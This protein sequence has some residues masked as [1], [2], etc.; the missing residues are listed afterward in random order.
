MQEAGGRG[1]ALT[2]GV[3]SLLLA[4]L[5]Q[6]A[7]PQA[8]GPRRRDLLLA[9]PSP[10]QPSDFEIRVWASNSATNRF[11]ARQVLAVAPGTVTHI[12]RRA[13]AAGDYFASADLPP[14]GQAGSVIYGFVSAFTRTARNNQLPL[15][16]H[17]GVSAPELI[18]D[19][20]FDPPGGDPRRSNSLV[21]VGRDTATGGNWLRRVPLAG[22]PVTGVVFGSGAQRLSLAIEPVSGDI[23]V[24][25]ERGVMHTL[26]A[27]LALASFNSIT[28]TLACTDL[29]LHTLPSG[30]RRLLAQ[31]RDVTST[32]DAIFELTP[33]AA[34]TAALV[35]PAPG[36]I[37]ALVVDAVHDGYCL[38]DAVGGGRQVWQWDHATRVLKCTNIPA[39]AYQS[40]AW[41]SRC[42]VEMIG[43]VPGTP[44]GAS[45]SP[46]RV[47]DAGLTFAVTA[48]AGVTMD[49]IGIMFSSRW[50]DPPSAIGPNAQLIVDANAPDFVFL[51]LFGARPPTVVVPC[52][53]IGGNDGARVVAQMLWVDRTT[54]EWLTSWAAN[55]VIGQ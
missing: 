13:A 55:F 1:S 21:V 41:T 27:S 53:L 15:R 43:A 20:E 45:L 35:S 5:V 6:P 7:V 33:G 18:T 40:I 38:V 42:T 22:G 32:G 31:G 17:Y 44:V 26:T 52:P 19:F 49:S 54:H 9:A 25:D 29:V 30:N 3:T 10:L 12:D 36:P 28:P 4:S 23:H 47:G 11:V 14:A 48:P 2:I 16:T 24:V 34:P 51:P 46:P 8:D 37:A 50:N 39:A